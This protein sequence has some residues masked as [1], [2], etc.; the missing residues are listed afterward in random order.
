MDIFIVTA[1]SE[2]GVY[3]PKDSR[4]FYTLSEAKMY[5]RAARKQDMHRSWEIWHFLD[6]QA[7]PE[8][9]RV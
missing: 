9:V 2:Q 8:E 6:G 5:V 1:L 4:L 3:C 7:E